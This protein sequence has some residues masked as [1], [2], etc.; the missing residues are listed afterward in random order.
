MSVSYLSKDWKIQKGFIHE[1]QWQY[2]FHKQD[3]KSN[4]Q[5]EN[6]QQFSLVYLV[7]TFWL[8]FGIKVQ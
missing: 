5:S 1:N 2:F 4:A 6:E 7:L 3:Q 8:N